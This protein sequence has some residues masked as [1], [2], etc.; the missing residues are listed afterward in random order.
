MLRQLHSH[1]QLCTKE[2]QEFHLENVRNIYKDILNILSKILCTY[3][4]GR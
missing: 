2:A 1:P 4:K 3:P